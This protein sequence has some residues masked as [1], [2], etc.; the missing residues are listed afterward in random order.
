MHITGATPG[1]KEQA[2]TEPAADPTP[3]YTEL[4]REKEQREPCPPAAQ[5]V[6]VEPDQPTP[7]EPD[8]PSSS[9]S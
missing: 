5:D 4:L 3:I 7:V 9:P 8:W 6:T 2:M 1:T